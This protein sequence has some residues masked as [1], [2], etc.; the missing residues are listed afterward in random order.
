MTA[1]LDTGG[2]VFAA[3]KCHQGN[4]R[5]KLPPEP[6]DA[7]FD[8]AASLGPDGRHVYLT[9][10]NRSIKED[11]TLEVKLTNLPQPLSASVRFLIAKDLRQPV[12]SSFPVPSGPSRGLVA[13][14]VTPQHG[15]FLGRE[16]QPAVDDGGRLEFKMPRA[17]VAVLELT[18]GK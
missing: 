13:N 16:E 17:S 18:S 1:R 11:R 2:M 7:D 6:A 15:I 12:F 3:F 10:I 8:V 5:R 4:R 9:I 14:D